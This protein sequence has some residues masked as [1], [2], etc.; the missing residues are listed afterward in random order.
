LDDEPTD[1]VAL[2]AWLRHLRSARP[3]GH[4][5]DGAARPILRFARGRRCGARLRG[6]HQ[7]SR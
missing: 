6:L 1:S 5:Q 3:D 7:R 2:P 4:E